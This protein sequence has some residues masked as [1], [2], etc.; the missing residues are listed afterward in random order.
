ME[1]IAN[2]VNLCK[3]CKIEILNT[4]QKIRCQPCIRKKRKI[5]SFRYLSKK[6]K[7][8]EQPNSEILNLPKRCNNCNKVKQQKDFYLR[9]DGTFRNICKICKC[10]YIKDQYE[11]NKERIKKYQ[12]NYR[13][14]HKDKILDYFRNRRKNDIQFK[15]RRSLSSSLRRALRGEIKTASS[16]KYLKC[17]LEYLKSYLE[18]LFELEMSWSNWGQYWH[19]DHIIPI[20]YYDLTEEKNKYKACNYT[21]LQPLLASKNESK[22]DKILHSQVKSPKEYSV[23]YNS[24]RKQF[25]KDF[26]SI[27]HYSETCPVISYAFELK[28]EKHT[29][30]VC[31]FSPPSR[32]GITVPNVEKGR[33]LELSR[34]FIYDHTPKNAETY[35][36]GHCLRWLGK[37]QDKYDAI[38]SF[39]DP[40]E[41]HQG[42]IYKA[43]NFT[44]LGQSKA[45][46]HYLDQQG[47]RVHKRRV[48][49]K[50]KKEGKTETV[51]YKELGLTKVKELPKNKFVYYLK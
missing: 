42:I 3:D 27:N 50:G 38:V 4:S 24:D 22:Q 47:N 49:T 17:T 48:W 46:Y 40:T 20:T 23:V 39:S 7:N 12:K 8:F 16:L 41:G 25:C 11:K 21:N 36:I 43:S 14:T 13:S 35:F 32:Q 18:S 9:E 28:Y 33:L 10:K 51:Y 31:I 6:L 45:N 30:G 15:L 29:I 1:S 37:N 19:L 2:S 26:I 5:Y 44:L 34:L